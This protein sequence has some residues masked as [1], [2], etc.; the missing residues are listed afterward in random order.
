ML[1]VTLPPTFKE[2]LIGGQRPWLIVNLLKYDAIFSSKAKCSDVHC[3][4]GTFVALIGVNRG[5]KKV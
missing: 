4:K 1:E 5:P 2:E 3:Y